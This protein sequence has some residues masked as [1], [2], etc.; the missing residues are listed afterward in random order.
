VNVPPSIG[1]VLSSGKTT[2]TEL[3]RLNLEA[4]YDLL[5]VVA[6]DAHNTRLMRRYIEKQR[7][8]QERQ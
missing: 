4:L 1:A 5:E 8:E 7:R 3:R 6:V 2:Y